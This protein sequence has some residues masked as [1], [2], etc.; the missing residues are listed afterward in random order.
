MGGYRK[1]NGWPATIREV[2]LEGL[3][4]GLDFEEPFE[5][6]R[7]FLEVV[8]KKRKVY[9]LYAEI[10]LLEFRISGPDKENDYLI[11][12][13]SN[14]VEVFS[15][16]V[17]PRSIHLREVAQSSLSDFVTPFVENRVLDQNGDSLVWEFE[18]RPLFFKRLE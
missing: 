11:R 7:E 15:L 1:L 2:V 14:K 10:P 3:H 18:R 9:L 6:L 4:L 17:N 16:Y 8:E 5:D 12:T 13:F